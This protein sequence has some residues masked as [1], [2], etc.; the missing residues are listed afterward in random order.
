MPSPDARE[1]ARA[2]AF[3]DSNQWDFSENVS[4]EIEVGEKRLI[5]ALAQ[6][7]AARYA[8]G[9]AAG[10]EA[11]AKIAEPLYPLLGAGAHIAAAIRATP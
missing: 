7:G 5:A 10:R 6:Y 3:L 11:A 4:T 8:E 1:V 9:V 2:R